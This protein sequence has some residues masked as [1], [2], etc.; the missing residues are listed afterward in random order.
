MTEENDPV[1][2][3]SSFSMDGTDL[4]SDFTYYSVDINKTEQ[5]D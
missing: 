4:V 1:L 3:G 2:I 5:G